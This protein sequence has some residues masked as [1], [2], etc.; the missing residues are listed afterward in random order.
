MSTLRTKRSAWIVVLG[1]L[2]ACFLG[3]C[4]EV[5]V[6]PP[7]TWP[8]IVT[9]DDRVQFYVS[10]LRVPGTRQEIRTKKGDANLWVPLSQVSSMRF[11]APVQDD[12]RPA[13]IVLTNGEILQVEVEANQILE[14]RTKA[15]YWNMPLS[16]IYS[17]ELG[18]E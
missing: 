11:T 4:A 16:R 9:T 3:A 15:G 5:Q 2:L 13:E 18:T 7:Q 17:L 6:A 8:S 1:L 12:Y 10:G 14:G